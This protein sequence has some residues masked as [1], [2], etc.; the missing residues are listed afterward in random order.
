MSG[1]AAVY[2]LDGRPADPGRLQ[3]LT[4]LVAHRG[5]DGAGHWLDGPVGLGH[6][7][8]H[9]TPEALRETQPLVERV[10][11]LGLVLDGRVDNRDEL[12]ASLAAEDAGLRSATDAELVLRAYARWGEAC[13]AR[14]VGDFAFV[15]WDGRRRALVCAR[16]P[17]GIRPLYY[18][19]D[20][21]T[22]L[23]GSELR[24]LLDAPGVSRRPNEAMLGEYLS[25]RVT[26]LE[27]T[28]YRDIRRLPPAH[29][30]TVDG[31]GVRTWR[32]WDVDPGRTIRYRS[33]A[34]YA[35]HF[36]TIFRET[37]RCRLRSPSPVAVFLSGGLDSSAIAVTA[38]QLGREG[39]IPDRGLEAYSLRFSVPAADEQAYVEAVVA[40]SGLK[41]H[42]VRADGWAPPGLAEQ[43]A[44][45]R[46]FPDFPNTSPW[47]RLYELARD[48]GSRV[49]LWG[50]GGDEWLTGDQTH[51]ADLLRR[52]RIPA[53]L[54]QLR[55]DRR[56]AGLWGG[57]AIDALEI[58]RWCVLPLVPRLRSAARRW[59]GRD[60][61]PWIA[62]AF[63]RR[64]ALADRLR[65][66]PAPRPFPTLAQQAIAAQLT[67]AWSALEYELL[68]RL[69]GALSMEGRSPFNDRRL[70][71][72]ALAL[73]EAQRWR[74]AETK[75]VLRT[76]TRG[77]LPEPVR[78]RASKADFS[79]LY[80][81]TFARER[82]DQVVAALRLVA[83]GYL[84]GPAT[85][86]L[87]RR[88][89]GG[90]VASFNPT[91]M[92]VGCEHWY[93][94]LGPAADPPPPGGD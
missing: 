21:R 46:D 76:A 40:A 23:C 57:E 12:R 54:R 89:R 56:V 3:R 48:R 72:F 84:D 8:L 91:W 66:L 62:P 63:A 59:L 20:G 33:D 78:Q 7:M 37:V 69:E 9:T 38:Q 92:I 5:P 93:R 50:H 73:P 11:P 16:D 27:D 67:S 43:V 77:L 80:P 81:E 26:D 49:V 71:E 68:S 53:L 17:I 31:G 6:R 24:Q 2:H 29:V 60:V 83:D 75:F 34:E 19:T 55:T 42:A 82:A 88:A 41:A 45:V 87:H 58:A 32:Y 36:T 39:A 13:A 64:V 22:F 86:T 70:V 74:G 52:L 30:L 61:P 18:A 79:Y 51:C 94:A 28:L 47:I 35:E 44:R 65:R 15:V 85:A 14:I 10:G 90:D 25:D 4:A 1:I